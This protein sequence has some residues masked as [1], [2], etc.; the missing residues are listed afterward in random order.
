VQI[1]GHANGRSVAVVGAGRAVAVGPVVHGRFWMLV[2][3]AHAG[4]GIRVVSLR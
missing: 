2:P 4:P 1:S 3:R